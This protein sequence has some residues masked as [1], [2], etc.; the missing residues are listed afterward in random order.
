M[1]AIGNQRPELNGQ[2]KEKYVIKNS[3]TDLLYNQLN[4][5]SNVGLQIREMGG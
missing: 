3:V 4:S 1:N 5:K 2:P